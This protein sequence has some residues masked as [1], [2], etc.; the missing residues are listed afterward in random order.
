MSHEHGSPKHD[1]N[2]RD[3]SNELTSG[4]RIA[5]E[6]VLHLMKIPDLDLQAVVLDLLFDAARVCKVEPQLEFS[7]CSD[8]VSQYLKRCILE[9][10]SSE[11]AANRWTACCTYANWFHHIWEMKDHRDDTAPGLK[12]MAREMCLSDDPAIRKT[13]TDAALEHLFENAEVRAFFSDWSKDPVLGRVFD[14]ASEWSLKGGYS[15]LWRTRQ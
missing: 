15:P 5:R 2:A 8:F 10:P 7:D 1:Q 6:R 4:E 3:V 9:N 11:Y 14:E 13:L 12:N